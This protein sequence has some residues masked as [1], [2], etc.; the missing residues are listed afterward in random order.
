MV[1]KIKSGGGGGVGVVYSAY[2]KKDLYLFSGQQCPLRTTM[3]VKPNNT[4]LNLIIMLELFP[5]RGNIVP[6]Y[7]GRGLPITNRLGVYTMS[8]STLA[9]AV[10]V[11][12]KGQKTLQSK[13][14]HSSLAKY[15]NYGISCELHKGKVIAAWKEAGIKP[16]DF[17]E[18]F[19]LA[20]PLCK[21]VYEGLVGGLLKTER[22]M[23]L[24]SVKDRKAWKQP[25]KTKYESK[26]KTLKRYYNSLLSGLTFAVN[27]KAAKGAKPKGSANSWTFDEREISALCGLHHARAAV[28]KETQRDV[29]IAMFWQETIDNYTA[30]FSTGAQ[31][32]IKRKFTA[33]KM[34][35]TF[36]PKVK[37]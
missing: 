28:E 21:A 11:A 8:K 19:N 25:R 20:N 29:D 16:S 7:P 37:K 22:A 33:G 24:S 36:S 17:P 1:P 12:V 32:A 4:L 35:V 27:G 23:M 26:H 13:I 18:T 6:A 9:V 3:S 10:E 15:A 14:S 34:S 30:T 5:S 31:K 2:Q